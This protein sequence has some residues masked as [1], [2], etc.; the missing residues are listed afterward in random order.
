MKSSRVPVLV[1]VL[2]VLCLSAVSNASVITLTSSSYGEFNTHASYGYTATGNLVSANVLSYY[3]FINLK[4]DLTAL[5]ADLANGNVIVSATLYYKRG[6]VGTYETT[7]ATVTVAQ[8]SVDP[9]TATSANWSSLVTGT[10]PNFV[11]QGV[12]IV[13]AAEVVTGYQN[14]NNQALAGG[15]AGQQSIDITAIVSSWASSAANYGINMASTLS[16]ERFQNGEVPY[17]VITTAPAPEPATIGLL[18]IGGI[19]TLLRRRNGVRV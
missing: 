10:N 11:L 2:A 16:L 17:I 6:Y 13:S 1:A 9:T 12:N 4:Y 19:A 3:T 18:A 14:Y 7:Q 15:Y 8:S 5:S